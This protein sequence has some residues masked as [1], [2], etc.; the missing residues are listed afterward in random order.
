[1]VNNEAE[2]LLFLVACEIRD[3]GCCPVGEAL[4][5]KPVNEYVSISN[6][7]RLHRVGEGVTERRTHCLH[8]SHF[9]APLASLMSSCMATYMGPSSIGRT[10][11]AIPVVA[12]ELRYGAGGRLPLAS[13]PSSAIAEG[14]WHCRRLLRDGAAVEGAS[15]AR[16]GSGRALLGKAEG[17]KDPSQH[18]ERYVSNRSNG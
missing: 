5:A 7:G 12:L 4:R 10:V 8:F 15:R 2:S 17:K 6:A 18:K 14:W 11:C 1:M 16:R 9:L 13:E 3:A